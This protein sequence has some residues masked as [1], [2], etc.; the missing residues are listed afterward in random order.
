ME[1]IKYKIV[2]QYLIKFAPYAMVMERYLQMGL[3]ATYMPLALYVMIK[4]L[5]LCTLTN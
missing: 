1:E 4:G 5:F 3:Q 2:M